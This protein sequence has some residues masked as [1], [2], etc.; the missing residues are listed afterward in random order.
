MDRFPPD[1]I[2]ET[3]TKWSRPGFFYHRRVTIKNGVVRLLHDGVWAFTFN[4]FFKVNDLGEKV[5][6]LVRGGQDEDQR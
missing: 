4:D 6:E 2:Y 5:G 1:G 3:R